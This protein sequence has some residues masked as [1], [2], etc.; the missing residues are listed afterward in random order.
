MAELLLD[1]N[2]RVWVFLPI[3]LIT[4]LIGIIRHY[5]T[6]LISSEKKSELQQVSDRYV[7]M[8]IA[9]LFR[10]FTDVQLQLIFANINFGIGTKVQTFRRKFIIFGN[11][12]GLLGKTADYRAQLKALIGDL[13]RLLSVARVPR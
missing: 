3:V 10:R 6:I 8:D 1:S 7:G 13:I 5:V 9:N 11:T 12:A 4:F 2:I